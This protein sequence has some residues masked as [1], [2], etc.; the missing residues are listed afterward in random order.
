MVPVREV[1]RT[2]GA[3]GKEGLELARK[4]VGLLC[5]DIS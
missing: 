4:E 5:K 2:S 1:M 3:K